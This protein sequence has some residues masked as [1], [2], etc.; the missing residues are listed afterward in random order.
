MLSSSWQA[1]YLQ[2]IRLLRR[3]PI[4]RTQL[5]KREESGERTRAHRRMV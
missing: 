1:I 5:K 4:E 2:T 3:L